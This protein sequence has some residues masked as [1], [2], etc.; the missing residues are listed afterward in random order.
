MFIWKQLEVGQVCSWAT[1]A[2]SPE[3]SPH[4]LSWNVPFF[5]CQSSGHI[6]GPLFSSLK[7]SSWDT[8][9]ASLFQNPITSQLFGSLGC[10]SSGGGFLL[11]PTGGPWGCCFFPQACPWHKLGK[12]VGD[13]SP[14]PSLPNPSFSFVSH[15]PRH[16]P[17]GAGDP[18]LLE[19]LQAG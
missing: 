17:V 1:V 4:R 18:N 14:R 12:E 5:P 2:S 7:E 3:F 10:L 11:L 8:R 16:L 9:S 15:T 19:E 13:P 6:G